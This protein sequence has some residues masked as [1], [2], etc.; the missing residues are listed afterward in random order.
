MMPEQLEEA[1]IRELAEHQK[2]AKALDTNATKLSDAEFSARY[3]ELYGHASELIGLL[4][5]AQIVG[6]IAEAV[7]FHWMELTAQESRELE[8][9]YLQRLVESYISFYE[10]VSKRFPGGQGAP[11]GKTP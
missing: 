6:T 7:P 9:T 2:R 5:A 11:G 10:A 3:L 1:I 8:R 4:R